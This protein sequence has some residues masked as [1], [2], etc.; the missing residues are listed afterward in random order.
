MLH[1]RFS[2]GRDST[3]TGGK[4][5]FEFLC[6]FVSIVIGWNLGKAPDRAAFTAGELRSD[7]SFGSF[8]WPTCTREEVN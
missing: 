2:L 1:V 7:S 8:V 5:G 3:V 4:P 6:H